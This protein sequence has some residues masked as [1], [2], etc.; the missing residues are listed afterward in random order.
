[1][2]IFLKKR[3]EI[4]AVEEEGL[5]RYAVK[6]GASGGRR[7]GE[8]EHR[9]RS[10]FQRDRDRVIHSAAFR[11]LEAKTQVFLGGESDYYRTRLTH[12]MEVAQVA[13][14]MARI[15]GVN[16]DLAE[17][18]ALA[19]DLGHPPYGHGGEGDPKFR[20]ALTG[21]ESMESIL[22]TAI[23]LEKKSINFYESLKDFVPAIPNG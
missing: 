19:H 4:E 5:A 6:S 11:R 2:S 9:W 15:L 7:Y 18:A 22:L 23:V 14:T 16:E 13:R 3:E 20:Q 1:M 10:C 17:A 12:T 8:A 21:N